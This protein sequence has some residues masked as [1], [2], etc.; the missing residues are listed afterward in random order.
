M[1][2]YVFGG[3]IISIIF[4]AYLVFQLPNLVRSFRKVK[5]KSDLNIVDGDTFN[6][7]ITKHLKLGHLSE[8]SYQIKADSQPI[9][10]T[11][12]D[13]CGIVRAQSVRWP[14]GSYFYVCH[15][16]SL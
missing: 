6:T 2:W 3:F 5:T 4:L 7:F 11:W 14:S 1:C 9:L 10:F 12:I 8:K 13:D 15:N 16:W